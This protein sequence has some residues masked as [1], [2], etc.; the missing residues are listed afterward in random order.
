MN[1]ILKAALF[2]L[3][4]QNLFP[5][6]FSNQYEACLLD[7]GNYNTYGYKASVFDNGIITRNP[8]A[9]AAKFTDAY[10]H[11]LIL[12]EGYVSVVKDSKI[13]YTRNGDFSFDLITRQMINRDGFILP[14]P[15][16]LTEEATQYDIRKNIKIYNLDINEC[17]AINNTYFEYDSAPEID[18]EGSIIFRC[19]ECSN[20]SA[21][22]CLLEMKRI[23]ISNMENIANADILLDNINLLI[24]KLEGDEYLSR[25]KND[26]LIT[27]WLPYLELQFI[28]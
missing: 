4:V 16:Q 11:F 28:E 10:Y 7:L 3:I 18:T 5:G 20:V 24:N 9:G 17:N 12:G 19:L 8:C 22:Y 21:F 2:F 1:Y 15:P 25:D 13:Y 26:Y 6:D 23:I 27:Q 14:L